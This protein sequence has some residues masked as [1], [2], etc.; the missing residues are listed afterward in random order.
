MK[1]ILTSTLGGAFKVDG[2]RVPSIF[3]K[4]NGLLQT[5]R[6][7]WI[8]N[9]KVM[10]ICGSPNDY[11]K[12]DSI[13]ECLKKSFPMSGLDISYIGKCDGRNEELIEKLREMDVC[14]LAG[15]HV[16]TQN[17]FMK[18]I[19]LKKRLVDFSGLLIAWSAG[20]MNCAAN[21]Y[22][23]PELEGEAADPGY[24][25]W[26]SGLGITEVNIFPHYQL[27]KDEYLDGMRVMEDITYVDSFKHKILAM[28]DGSYIM[29]KDGK[30]I[31]FGEAYWIKDGNREQACKNGESVVLRARAEM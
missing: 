9:A 24:K 19:Y 25:R 13:C 2:K 1:A 12:N 4:E 27:L 20:S 26:I 11:E 31:L 8:D 22:A 15:G 10:I 18:K 14:V 30:E 17:S 6:E 28:N 29:I 21:V 7:E 23:A 16:P 3:M 5:L